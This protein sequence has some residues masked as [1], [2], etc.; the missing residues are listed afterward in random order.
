[1]EL[2]RA[3][4]DSRRERLL[5]R[6]NEQAPDWDSCIV[7]SKV[8]Q[9]Y[10]TGTMAD[11]MYILKR[12]GD[13]SYHIRKGYQRA[14]AESP[15][16]NIYPMHSYRDAAAQVGKDLGKAYLELDTVSYGMVERLQ[17]AF[18]M[19][20]IA[21]LERLILD[22]RAVKSPYEL[23]WMKEA[24]MAHQRTM[25][26]VPAIVFEGMSEMDLVSGLFQEMTALGYQGITRFRSFGTE[27]VLGQFGFG[28]STLT[29]SSFDGPAGHRGYGAAAPVGGSPDVFL[30]KGN[31]VFVDMGFGKMGYHTD[32]T[33]VF[34]YGNSVPQ[35]AVD[36]H[37]YC[38]GIQDEIA[39]RLVPGA[40]PSQ[41]YEEIMEKIPQEYREN[42][43]GAKGNTVR[44]LGHGVGLHVDEMPVIAKGF[45]VPLVENMTIALEPK[46][47]LEGIGIVGVEETYVVTP[48][49][50]Q[51]ITGGNREIIP[52]G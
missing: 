25:E 8:N 18:S 26:R 17:K 29:P 11:G 22:V 14:V 4:L 45:D 32:K 33:Q 50:G 6:L 47:G 42:F 41:I 46:I 21:N 39:A 43:M 20:G 15:L 27:I 19:K 5:V 12:D 16:P 7:L 36:A 31:L 2:T 40:I 23:Y 1:M 37:E 52:I 48:D 3:E 38:R 49:G 35:E 13:Y 28:V 30:Q 51:C 10:L 44:F 9:Y 24:G 34:Y